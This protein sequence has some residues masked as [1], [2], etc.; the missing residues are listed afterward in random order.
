M[1]NVAPRGR[2]FRRFAGGLVVLLLGLVAS[3]ATPAPPQDLSSAAAAVFAQT[4][5][6]GS[7]AFCAP[8]RYTV[9]TR[10]GPVFAMVSWGDRV[11]LTLLDGGGTPA[12][13]DALRSEMPAGEG[14]VTL[15][16]APAASGARYTAGADDRYLFWS[17]GDRALIVLGGH[18]FENAV[19]EPLQVP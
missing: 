16:H 18:R 2:G 11:A 1:R 14:M 6:D 3:C 9:T 4:A 12:Q 8:G 5:D 17:K 10:Q 7:A 19:V 13:R 15:T